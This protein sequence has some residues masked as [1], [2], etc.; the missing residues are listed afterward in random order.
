M[1]VLTSTNATEAIDMSLLDQFEYD[2]WD[3]TGNNSSSKYSWL[4]PDGSDV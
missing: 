2:S 4:T 3:S 1:A